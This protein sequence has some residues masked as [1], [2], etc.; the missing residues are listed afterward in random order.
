MSSKSKI[1]I[2]EE[3][4]EE[5]NLFRGIHPSQWDEANLR[6]SSAAFKDRKG[7]SVDRCNMRSD[8]EAINHLLASKPFRGIVKFGVI[9][10]LDLPS[11]VLYKP[12]ADNVF[13]S[14]M[15]D[16]QKLE[17]SRGKAK[18]LARETNIVYEQN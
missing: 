2:S 13:H 9:Y 3:I 7:L 16:L 17:L 4:S 8:S 12:L 1:E 18:R 15:H 5:E 14:E 11:Q 10:A 6:P